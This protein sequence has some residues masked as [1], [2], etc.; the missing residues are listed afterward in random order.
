VF[1]AALPVAV[2]RV[3]S[4]YGWRW[5]NGRDDL[6][7]GVDIGAPEGTPVYAML[8]G[9][10]RVAAPS[11]ALSGYGNVVVLQHGANVF[12]LYAHLS[13][14]DVQ[15]GRALELGAP[16]GLV[17]RTAGTRADPGKMFATSGAHLHLE[18]LD[19]W[20]P[21]GRDQN[22][23]DPGQVLPS[24]GIIVPAQG[25][26]LQMSCSNAFAAA[27]AP[28]VASTEARAQT[29]YTSHTTVTRRS[30]G[31]AVA[32]VALL[33]ASTWLGHKHKRRGL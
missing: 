24:L 13:R 27:N 25:Q 28:P 6:H 8:P 14:V 29:E 2:G 3:S 11:G 18:F 26:P 23:V 31:A 4:P 17:G 5:L 1:C 12:T 15:E 19:A 33:A 22:R 21:A 20:P 16:L 32:L 30:S 7:T 10:V 9:T